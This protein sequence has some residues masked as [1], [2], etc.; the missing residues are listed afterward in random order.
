MSVTGQ[1]V[2]ATGVFDYTTIGY[3]SAS[4]TQQWIKHPGGSEL[5][6]NSMAVSP[7]TGTVFVTGA[8]AADYITIAYSG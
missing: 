3:N 7:A 1:S 2:A 6:P 4:G 8:N 5:Y